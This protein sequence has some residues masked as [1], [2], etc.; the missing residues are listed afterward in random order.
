M[1]RQLRAPKTL[2]QNEQQAARLHNPGPVHSRARC[3][4]LSRGGIGSH[5]NGSGRECSRRSRKQSLHSCCEL[6][7]QTGARK[8]VPSNFCKYCDRYET[9]QI[10]RPSHRKM[11]CTS[12]RALHIVGETS[13]FALLAHLRQN[14]LGLGEQ[15]RGKSR[16]AE[17]PDAAYA[18][19]TDLWRTGRHHR[20]G[21]AEKD[22]VSNKRTPTA[23]VVRR[24]SADDTSSSRN[25]AIAPRLSGISRRFSNDSP[26]SRT[27]RIF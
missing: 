25:I 20:K 9:E 11:M 24:C 14:S 2:P 23:P 21:A 10:G 18:R 19:R 1:P 6:R 13:P 5:Q 7:A 27:S 26:G 15:R 4:A 3:R 16:T 8:R 17:K 22:E 12:G